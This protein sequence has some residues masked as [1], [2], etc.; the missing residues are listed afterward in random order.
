DALNPGFAEA[1][2][3]AAIY[4]T[5]ADGFPP[6][7]ERISWRNEIGLVYQGIFISAD[8]QDFLTR[9]GAQEF[10]AR[11]KAQDE[12]L[13]SLYRPSCV[14]PGLGSAACSRGACS[15]PERMGRR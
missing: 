1:F 5:I 7:F 11:F 15:L 9:K 8:E 3:K 14:S 12:D 10:E 13:C 6:G 2:D 4:Y